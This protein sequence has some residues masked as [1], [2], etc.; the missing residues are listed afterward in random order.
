MYDLGK[1]TENNK[2]GMIDYLHTSTPRQSP[3]SKGNN[4]QRKQFQGQCGKYL[5][6]LASNDIALESSYIKE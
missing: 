5:L 2:P 6:T 4:L 1:E 3:A